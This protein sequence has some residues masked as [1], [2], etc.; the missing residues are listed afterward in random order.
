[1]LTSRV[2]ALYESDIFA[3]D[4][5]AFDGGDILPTW[6][7]ISDDTTVDVDPD[8]MDYTLKITPVTNSFFTVTAGDLIP[9]FA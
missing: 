5:F 1:M 4:A 9:N 8:S 2:P 3:T 7:E 6:P